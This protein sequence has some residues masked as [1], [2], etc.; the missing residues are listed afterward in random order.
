MKILFFADLRQCTNCKET[1]IECCSTVEELLQ[2]LC[3]MYGKKFE[4]RV[5]KGKG[6]SDEI[7][8]LVNGRNIINMDGIK[9]G[10]NR[11]DIISIFPVVAGG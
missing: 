1:S 10:L 8:V 5:L 6:W 2:I 11:D 9:T 7:I 4:N 3:S